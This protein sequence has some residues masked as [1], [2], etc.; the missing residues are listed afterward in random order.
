[1]D[2]CFT[3]ACW[4][5]FIFC[6]TSEFFIW[7]EVDKVEIQQR[8]DEYPPGLYRVAN[9]LENKMKYFYRAKKIFFSYFDFNSGYY[10]LAP[11]VVICFF[12]IFDK[13]KI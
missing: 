3:I 6:S 11:L 9:I 10:L 5:S 13:R 4:G 7:S 8:M 2:F 12:E 1:M